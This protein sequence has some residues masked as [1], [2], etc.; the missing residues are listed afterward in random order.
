MLKQDAPTIVV[1]SDTQ[2]GRI[3]IS[4]YERKVVIVCEG[5]H[6]PVNKALQLYLSKNWIVL[7]TKNYKNPFLFS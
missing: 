3:M 7:F 4:T 1:P 6:L 5:D 2:H